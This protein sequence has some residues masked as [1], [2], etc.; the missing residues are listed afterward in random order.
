MLTT[1]R[2]TILALVFLLACPVAFAGDACDLAVPNFAR[3]DQPYIA[4]AVDCAG[5]PE[6]NGAEVTAAA[7]A[8]SS[9]SG[10]AAPFQPLGP[11]RT[12]GLPVHV[13]RL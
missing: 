6:A 12:A 1:T 13:D 11:A 10:C 7:T 4:N 3:S 5:P 9:A 8:E 2:F